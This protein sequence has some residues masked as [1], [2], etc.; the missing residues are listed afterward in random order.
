[1]L[2]MLVQ[3]SVVRN[4]QMQIYGHGNLQMQGSLLRGPYEGPPKNVRR[5]EGV[6]G[7]HESV[8]ECAKA[9]EAMAATIGGLGGEGD[10]TPW[11][12]L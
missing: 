11:R 8:E 9:C 6:C 2:S 12:R 4:P 1:M 10:N 5:H 7:S 3:D